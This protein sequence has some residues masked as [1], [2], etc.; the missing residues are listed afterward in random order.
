MS[1]PHSNSE[2]EATPN[3]RFMRNPK[4]SQ[5]WSNWLHNWQLPCFRQ[6]KFVARVE[7]GSPSYYNSLMRLTINNVTEEDLGKYTCR[8]RNSLGETSG[9]ITLY[10]EI[11][12]SCL[13]FFVLIYFYFTRNCQEHN[14]HNSILWYLGC[15]GDHRVWLWRWV[16]GWRDAGGVEE[17]EEE[18]R[19]GA[20]T[21]EEGQ[22]EQ[23]ETGATVW[24]RLLQ[25]L[26]HHSSPDV[27]V[28]F[29]TRLVNH[30]I[31]LPTN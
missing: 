21:Q 20:Q 1:S 28:K 26:L 18:E 31:V 4:I 13:T 6:K 19:G 30:V 12:N 14:L 9:E 5:Q 2:D 16:W 17:G 7:E 22:G 11:V 24:E 15:L 27:I 3:V 25:L 8:A 23:E 29:H 10:G